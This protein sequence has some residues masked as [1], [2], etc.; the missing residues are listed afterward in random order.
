MPSP[1]NTAI[2]KSIVLFILICFVIIFYN[3]QH[4]DG[5][6]DGSLCLVCIQ[7]SGSEDSSIEIPCNVC[8]HEC[9]RTSAGRN[10][11]CIILQHGK[12]S[13]QGTLVDVADCSYKS[14]ILSVSAGV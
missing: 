11:D 12:L 7:P 10:A 9:I 6:L 3:I 5:S 8:L 13:V 4:L 14:I 1:G 2:F